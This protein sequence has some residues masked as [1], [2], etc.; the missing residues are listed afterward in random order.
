MISI[1]FVATGV[2]ILDLFFIFFFVP[3]SL[4]ERFRAEEKISW[5]K[6]DPF[7]VNLTFNFENFCFIMI[8]VFLHFLNQAL[9]SI[10]RDRIICLICWILFLSYL[11][12]NIINCQSRYLH[13]IFINRSRTIFMLLCVFTIGKFSSIF[14]SLNIVVIYTDAWLFWRWSRVFH[15]IHW[16]SILY[17]SSETFSFFSDF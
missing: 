5:R 17:C 4:P 16:D 8:F 14:L 15:C 12:G 11:P 13:S 6:I 9:R 1:Y 2:A 7:A 10:T 3:E